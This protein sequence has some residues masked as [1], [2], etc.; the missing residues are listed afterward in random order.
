MTHL[1]DTDVVID[2]LRHD[3]TVRARLEPLGSGVAISS[4]TLMELTFGIWRS[5]RPEANG[6]A[7]DRFLDFVSVLDFGVEA[8]RDAGRIRAEL[9]AQGLPIGGYDVLI[10]GHARALGLTLATR[11]V[12]EFS[13]VAGLSV[14][15]WRRG[16]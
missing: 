15:D 6:A 10:A 3:P 11:N 16:R 8:A 9:A 12:R 2:I 4:I 5:N 7:V 1:L 13:R 14:A